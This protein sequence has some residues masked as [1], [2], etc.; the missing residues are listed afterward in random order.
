MITYFDSIKAPIIAHG[1]DL[2]ESGVIHDKSNLEFAND[3]MACVLRQYAHYDENQ[4][5]SIKSFGRY[6]PAV[7]ED[8]LK[9]IQF[10]PDLR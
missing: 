1:I 4:V 8:P 6:F 10:Q 3:L 7:Y 2:L 5:Q 9:Y